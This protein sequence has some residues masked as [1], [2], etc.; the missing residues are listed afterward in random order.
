[1]PRLLIV[2]SLLVLI[3]AWVARWWF[4]KRVRDKGRRV[5]CS[6][7]VSE[8]CDKLGQPRKKP[9]DV[10]DAAAL[11]SALRDCGLRLLE[12]DGLVLAKQR[13]T[14]WWSLKI[15][16]VLVGIIFVFSLIFQRVAPSWILAVGLL[17]IALHVLLR[18][19]GLG[20][21]LKAVRRGLDEL[22]KKGGFR[23]ISEEEAVVDCAKASVWETILPW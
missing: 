6:M 8:L 2:L 13:R 20:I 5:G 17:I 11:G 3:A 21:E 7:S 14:G 19:S 22:G 4:W 10:K 15:L 18:V 23:R 1:M 9:N 12:R 16:P